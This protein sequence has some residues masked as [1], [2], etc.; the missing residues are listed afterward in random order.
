MISTSLIILIIVI[1]IYLSL[2]LIVY[3]SNS[4]NK[5]NILFVLLIMSIIIWV[6]S[7]FFE[8]EKIAVNFFGLLLKIDFVFAA[9]MAYFWLLFVLNFPKQDKN[10]TFIKEIL[11]LIPPI[12]FAFLIFFD[13]IIINIRF[14]RN[15]IFDA[16]P[17]FWFYA[18]Y[19][20]IYFVGGCIILVSKYFKLS[21]TERLQTFYVVLGA[22]LTALIALA[23]NLIL[24]QIFPSVPI[25][26]SRIGIYSF[27]FLASFTTYSIVKHQLFDIRVILTETATVL[28]IMALLIQVLLSQNTI[29]GVTNLVILIIVS[30]GGYLLI[31][32]VKDEIERRKQLQILSEQLAHANSHLKELDKMK[33]EFVSLASHELLTPVSAIEGYLSMML[34]EKLARIDDPK[35]I[36]Y[37]DQVYRSAKRLARLVTDMLNVSRIE[38]G[39]LLVE[40]KEVSLTGVITQ[41][42]DELKFKAEE[43]K[44]KITFQSANHWETFGD[45]DKIKEIL[46]NLIGNSIKYSKNPGEIEL[47][48]ETVPTEQV[49]ETWG[50]VEG[51]IKDRPLDDQEAIKSAVD[52]RLKRLVGE[53]QI[54]IHVK[55]QGVGIPREELPRLFKK[56]HRVG[57]Y[58]TA[59]SQG[60][61][62]GLYITRALVELHHGRVWADSEGQGKGSVFTF[63][64]PEAGVQKEIQD[65]EAQ[66]P[67]RGDMK[68]LARPT[69]QAE[70]L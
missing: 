44:Q 63:S 32:S 49:K 39:R 51:A 9:L 23:V 70:E 40:K 42:I 24:P 27:L 50:K 15:V 69:K 56:F 18:T 13:Q 31:K 12:L 48:L 11:L 60:T 35:A 3:F 1:V 43:K 20:F 22:F 29:E 46:I 16:G 10:I 38:E 19:C 28:V 58:T 61:G 65:L 5:T 26:I 53:R 57:D 4:K 62:L 30:Y 59:E 34:D 6:C 21:G 7:N 14:D 64:L 55:D 36:H 47:L 54:L 67:H 2:G 33:T 17:L 52:E 45:S 8:N 37:M 68:P 41:T 66:V 25:D